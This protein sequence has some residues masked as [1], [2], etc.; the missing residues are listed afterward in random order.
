MTEELKKEREEEKVLTKD[1]LLLLLIES[2]KKREEL[3][4]SFV[5]LQADFENFR[6]RARQEKKEMIERAAEGLISEIIPILDNFQRALEVECKDENFKKG[7]AMIYDQLTQ[8]LEKWGLEKFDAL[9]KMF[10][11]EIHEALKCLETEEQE[12]NTVTAQFQ[13]GYTLKGKLLRPALVEVAVP[14]ATEK[15]AAEKE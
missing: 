5:R 6:R 14:P 12:K 10:N 1:E 13:P 4:N 11:P 7:V 9:G 3:W 8:I 15:K 2:E